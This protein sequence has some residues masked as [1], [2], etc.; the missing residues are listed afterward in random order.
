VGV[1]V[2]GN[3]SIVGLGDK[4][5]VGSGSG[6]GVGFRN[7]RRTGS[8]QKKG[9]NKQPDFLEHDSILL[10]SC[11]SFLAVDSSLDFSVLW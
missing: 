7:W 9:Q 6:S 8:Q 3:Q 4:T 1:G 10:K 11:E 2:L 5:R